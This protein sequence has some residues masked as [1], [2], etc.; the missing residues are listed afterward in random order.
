M[1]FRVVNPTIALAGA[2][3]LVGASCASGSDSV[4]TEPTDILGGFPA[5]SEKFNAIGM[6][7]G[8]RSTGPAPI[9]TGTLIG[10]HTVLAAGHC[11]RPRG[12]PFNIIDRFPVYFRIGYDSAAPVQEI[13]AIWGGVTTVA[14]HDVGLY[15]LEHDAA[16][17]TPIAVSD[18][19][20]TAEDLG[21]K[22][23]IVGYGLQ[24]ADNNWLQF[25]T[26]R[27]AKFEV[28]SFRP[29]AL[30]DLF[31]D[32]PTFK[33][34]MEANAGHSFTDDQALLLWNHQILTA[35]DV[36][37]G[38]PWEAQISFLDSGA[39]AMTNVDDVLTIHGV[40]SRSYDADPWKPNTGI[41]SDLMPVGT[42]IAMTGIDGTREMIDNS[43]ADP[44]R[45]VT[46][47]GH[48]SAT[49]AIRCP[50][51]LPQPTIE[52]FDCAEFGSACVIDADGLAGCQ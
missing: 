9:C 23:T 20:L 15:Q 6:L 8:V 33:A 28:T 18:V 24:G 30:Q 10:P 38:A 13:R 19:P 42:A 12:A 51:E 39:P 41:A 27:A 50:A 4:D 11:V 52:T 46:S 49:L 26:R 35:N 31:D 36:W 32:F 21:D 5:R 48:C 16:G 44:C 14:G 3:A 45:N 25:L 17:V 47:N 29:E 7:L 40:N 2:V 43:L 22:V 37:V 34:Y 1:T